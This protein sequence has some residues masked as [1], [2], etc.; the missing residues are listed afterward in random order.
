VV[1]QRRDTRRPAR[2]GGAEEAR[3]AGASEMIV[4][5]DLHV[6]AQYLFDSLPTKSHTVTARGGCEVA[7][8]AVWPAEENDPRL[9]F[10]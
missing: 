5:W 1:V 2:V 10:A 6:L 8:G 9:L 7:A 4:I 3:E